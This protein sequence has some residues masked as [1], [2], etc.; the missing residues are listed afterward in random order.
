MPGIAIDTAAYAIRHQGRDSSLTERC[1]G[2]DALPEHE[3]S[4]LP[5]SGAPWMTAAERLWF[6][7]KGGWARFDAA[8]WDASDGRATQF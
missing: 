3:I 6:D 7:S 5:T 8:G 1:F 2:Y 4:W